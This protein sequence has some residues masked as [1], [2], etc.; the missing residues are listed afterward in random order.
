MVETMV[1]YKYFLYRILT[2]PCVND[3]S[4]QEFLLSLHDGHMFHNSKS[5]DDGLPEKE[6]RFITAQISQASFCMFS[7]LLL[8]FFFFYNKIKSAFSI[9]STKLLFLA[10]WSNI[11]DKLFDIKNNVNMTPCRAQLTH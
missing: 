3:R 9:L 5:T 7:F 10:Q 8:L 1:N 2:V 6:L 11:M 4:S